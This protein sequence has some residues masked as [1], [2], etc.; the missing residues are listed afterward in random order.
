MASGWEM[1]DSSTQKTLHTVVQTDDGPY[2]VGQGGRVITR[3]SSG[4]MTTETDDTLGLDYLAAADVVDGTK[5][6]LAGGDG[7]LGVYDVT[8]GSITDY[9]QP[10][11]FEMDVRGL[12][13]TGTTGN[14]RIYASA[15]D[16][17]VL[18]GRRQ[19]DGSFA[20]EEQETG[21]TNTVSAVDFHAPEAG[22]A[23][24]TTGN[25]FATENAG[26]D[27]TDVGIAD[28]QNGLYTVRSRQDH[29]WTGGGSGHIWRYD[30]ECANWTPHK[31]GAKAVRSLA[32]D[33]D[34]LL[35]VGDSGRFFER[36]HLNRWVVKT[37]PTGNALLGCLLGSP[38]VAVGKGGVLL[39]R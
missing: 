3:T 11:S 19:P 13:V 14:E 36:N 6:W 18:Y 35:G 37:T 4:W 23:V 17:V 34:R 21:G 16:G 39:E 9:S 26:T 38:D 25:V 7:T 8:D 33:G 29:V 5:L 32:R 28:A 30:C 2:A 24:T 31:A 12:A 10:N 1:V 20:W 15:G 22:H 27:W